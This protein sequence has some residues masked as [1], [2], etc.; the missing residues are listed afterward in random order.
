MDDHCDQRDHCHHCHRSIDMKHF[1]KASCHASSTQG[2][3]GVFCDPENKLKVA[4]KFPAN[5]PQQLKLAANKEIGLIFLSEKL[6][7]HTCM[8]TAEKFKPGSHEGKIYLGPFPDE[9]EGW[10]LV[11]EDACL[12]GREVGVLKELT[13]LQAALPKSLKFRA[14]HSAAF[15]HIFPSLDLTPGTRVRSVWRCARDWLRAR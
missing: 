4:C 13:L 6:T 3:K 5:Y 10:F 8:Y 1:P 14:H 7:V 12:D 2:S 9:A 15:P 11:I